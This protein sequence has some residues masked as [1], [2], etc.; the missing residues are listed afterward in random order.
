MIFNSYR[1]R[2]PA[3]LPPDD[4]LFRPKTVKLNLITSIGLDFP[5]VRCRSKHGW[6]FV[7]SL[8]NLLQ[9]ADVISRRH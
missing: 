9:K 5:M 3:V 4:V 1:D 7:L 8:S 6:S 2:D